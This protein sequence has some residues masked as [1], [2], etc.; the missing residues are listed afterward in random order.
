M[1]NKA[2]IC[3]L[4]YLFEQI[5]EQILQM[6]ICIKS[7]QAS[8]K[9][10]LEQLHSSD[11]RLHANVSACRRKNQILERLEDEDEDMKI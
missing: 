6:I 3:L 10:E 2:N 7:L 9:K 5:W 8:T 11:D 1:S 4:L